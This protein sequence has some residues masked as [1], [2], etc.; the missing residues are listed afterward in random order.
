MFF[1]PWRRSSNTAT[2]QS[3][4]RAAVFGR[5]DALAMAI[6]QAHAERMLQI[7][8]RSGNVGLEVFEA[9]RRLAHA[10]GLHD[11]HEDVQVLQL[12]PAADA[13]AQLHGVTHMRMYMVSS[14]NSIIR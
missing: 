9:P 1:T 11:G 12:H 7:R 14:N 13:I 3:S 5:L 4:K 10:A 8:D 2:P 6:E